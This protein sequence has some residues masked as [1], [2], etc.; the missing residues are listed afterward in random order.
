VIDVVERQIDRQPPKA[1]ETL[2]KAFS[3]NEGERT[4]VLENLIRDQDYSR[5]GMLNAVT[6]A[7]EK[8]QSYDRATRLEETGGRILDLN[9]TEWRRIAEAVCFISRRVFNPAFQ[10]F[11]GIDQA[12]MKPYP[13]SYGSKNPIGLIYSLTRF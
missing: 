7:A 8:A 11:R 4:S 3:L 2:G 6:A 13:C 10:F 12:G 9:P 1:V 5:W